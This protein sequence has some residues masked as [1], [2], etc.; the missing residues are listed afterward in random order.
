MFAASVR[1]AML[2]RLVR[3]PSLEEFHVLNCVLQGQTDPIH[4][5]KE[6]DDFKHLH[7]TAK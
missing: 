2:K 5:L 7:N 1:Y 3:I 4:A 6:K